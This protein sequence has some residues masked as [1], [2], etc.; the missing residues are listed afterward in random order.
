M[1]SIENLHVRYGG[2]H[3]LKGVSIH[4]RENKI[5]ALLGSNGAGKS[6]TVRAV[7]GVAPIQSGTIS[8]AGK[9]LNGL[10]AHEIQRLGL[11]QIPEGRKIFSNLTVRENLFMGA[12]N[13][14][15][16]AEVSKRMERILNTFTAL[17]SKLD[18]KGGTLSGGQQQML[19]IGRALISSPRLMMMDEPSLGLAPMMVGEVF[20]VIQEIRAEGVTIFLI[21]QNADAALRVADDAYVMETGTIVLHGSGTDLMN[22]P[23]VKQAYLGQPIPDA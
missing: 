23:M 17:E 13:T 7:S 4:V 16:K 20:R 9:S 19:A 15:N 12:Y 11:V 18:Q 3:A 21:E 14:R 8:F 6:T 10:S 5:V 22:H 2:I 1:L